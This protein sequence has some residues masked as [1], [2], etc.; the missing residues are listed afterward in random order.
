MIRPVHKQFG[1]WLQAS[2][3]GA[4]VLAPLA[5][6]VPPGTKD[7]IKARLQP[8]GSVCRTGEDCGSAGP[9]A[10]SGPLSGEDVYGKFCFACHATGASGAPMMGHAD[11][12]GPRAAK[13]ID[14]LMQS[15]LNGLNAMPPRGTCA[16]CSDDEL[17][18][19]VEHMLEN[20][21]G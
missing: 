5:M 11:Q 6:A 7:Q 19:A 20:S 15:T 14:A 16:T 17:K 21:K 8:V 13:G 10:A 1:K 2:L 3:F 12:W 9:A 18:A 4:L